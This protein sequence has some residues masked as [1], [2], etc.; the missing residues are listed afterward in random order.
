MVGSGTVSMNSNNKFKF[1]KTDLSTTHTTNP[2]T[3]L[4]Y[5]SKKKSR[6]VCKKRPWYN[7]IF[8]SKWKCWTEYYW[9]YEEQKQNVP[10]G[11][12]SGDKTF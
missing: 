3:Y 4:K 2:T 7:R 9:T 6:E 10:K 12:I 11:R 5:I 1:Y 8:R